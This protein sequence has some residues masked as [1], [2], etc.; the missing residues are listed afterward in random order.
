LKRINLCDSNINSKVHCKHES[1]FQLRLLIGHLESFLSKEDESLEKK[2]S[3]EK[4][5]LYN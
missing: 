2:S 3:F 1:F 5:L 4:M